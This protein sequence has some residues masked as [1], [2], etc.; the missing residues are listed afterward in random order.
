MCTVGI[1]TKEGPFHLSSACL[2]SL[3]SSYTACCSPIAHS[4]AAGWTETLKGH[5]RPLEQEGSSSSAH[6]ECSRLGEGPGILNRG[7]KNLHI[8]YMEE[9]AESGDT[10]CIQSTNV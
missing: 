8:E 2:S 3:P 10:S 5:Q 6:R 7:G 1:H 9:R 4:G